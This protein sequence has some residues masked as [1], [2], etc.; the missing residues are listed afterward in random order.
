MVELGPARSRE[1]AGGV[2][3]E[4]GLVGFDGDRD[5][6]LGNR[7]GE[8]GL[9]AGRDVGEGGEGGGVAAFLGRVAGLVVGLGGGGVGCCGMIGWG[10]VGWEGANTSAQLAQPDARR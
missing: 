3:L 9:V 4:T 7:G 5:W 1:G 6:A 8:L 2:V 10:S